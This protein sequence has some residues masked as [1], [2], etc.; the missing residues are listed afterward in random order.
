MWKQWNDELGPGKELFVES[1]MLRVQHTGV[2]DE[3]EKQTLQN[4]TAEGLR[5]TQF[6]LSNDEDRRR[7]QERGWAH[8]LLKFTIPKTNS[9]ETFEAVLDST[10]GYIYP[11]DACAYLADKLRKKGAEFSEGPEKGEFASF[12]VEGSDNSRRVTGIRT[13]DGREHPADLVIMA[14]KLLTSLT[15]APIR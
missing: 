11:S 14:C 9:P 1:G 10:A 7:A 2:L 6:V 5:D 15:H 3:R 4:M 13:K 8:K 12:L